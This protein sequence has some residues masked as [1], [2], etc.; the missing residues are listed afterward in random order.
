MSSTNVAY[1]GDMNTV[2]QR[3]T[4]LS[5]F[6][7][8]EAPP[9]IVTRVDFLKPLYIRSKRGTRKVLIC[10][11]MPCEVR[12]IHLE[13]MSVQMV[14]A[15]L[16]SFRLFVVRKGLPSQV[17]SDNGKTFKVAAKATQEVKWIVNVP[18]AP[19]WGGVFEHIMRCVKQLFRKMIGQSKPTDDEILTAL[20]EVKMVLN[21]HPLAMVSAMGLE[22]PLTPSHPIVG[23]KLMVKTPPCPA[24]GEFQHT[25]SDN[26]TRHASQVPQY[27]YR[28]FLAEMEGVL[29]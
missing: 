13:L 15:F 4:P 19:W 29:G 5:T 10:L 21:S 16:Q 12:A 18:K 9:F 24:P 8:E 26:L 6:Q 20:N 3:P 22:E 14:P 17:V 2:S 23:Q 25:T 7:V 27:Y 1:V 28:A 11:Y